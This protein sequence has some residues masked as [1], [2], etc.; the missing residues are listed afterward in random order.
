MQATLPPTAAAE[1]SHQ[2]DARALNP[3]AVRA[4]GSQ[5][6]TPEHRSAPLLVRASPCIRI[7]GLN[8]FTEQFWDRWDRGTSSLCRRCPRTPK[9]ALRLVLSHNCLVNHPLFIVI[10]TCRRETL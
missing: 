5:Q 4:T 9:R 2:R 1:V 10:Y 3:T 7:L 8:L 6:Q